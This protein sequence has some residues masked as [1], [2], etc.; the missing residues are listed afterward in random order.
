M[1]KYAKW[2]ILGVVIAIIGVCIFFCFAPKSA[3]TELKLGEAENNVAYSTIPTLGNDFIIYNEKGE[4]WDVSK[5]SPSYSYFT[6]TNLTFDVILMNFVDVKQFTQNTYPKWIS[7]FDEVETYFFEESQGDFN[8][9]FNISVADINKNYTDMRVENKSSY[10]SLFPFTLY[11]LA[12]KNIHTTL[13]NVGE[14]DCDMLIVS[15]PEDESLGWSTIFW[16]KAT[17]AGYVQSFDARMI[18]SNSNES[19]MDVLC[20][21]IYHILGLPDLYSLQGDYVGNTDMMASHSPTSSTSA[22][23]KQKLGWYNESNYNDSTISNIENISSTGTYTLKMPKINGVN[24]YKFGI[25]GNEYFLAEPR[26][27]W[28]KQ[29]LVVNRIN[30]EKY[31]NMNAKS[32]EDTVVYAFPG[33]SYNPGIYIR[34]FANGNSVGTDKNPLF[35]SDGTRAEY[36]IYN[37]KTGVDGEITFDF[38]VTSI[39]GDLYVPDD[40]DIPSQIKDPNK[41]FIYV[42][43]ANGANLTPTNIYFYNSQ[44]DEWEEHNLLRV[45]VGNKQYF[46]FMYNEEHTKIKVTYKEYLITYE[47]ELPIATGVEVYNVQFDKTVVG[48]VGDFVN[49][50]LSG[51]SNFV[52]GIFNFFK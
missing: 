6:G 2:T 30:T 20:H 5:A 41:R 11:G 44:D 36:M 16:P 22:Y 45:Y 9:K 49:G 1:P 46:T 39:D 48:T 24:A 17:V 21:E 47:K 28:D 34:L 13:Q 14:G 19:R 3:T 18:I 10:N 38:R 27:V 8:V 52:S 4:V 15:V 29:Y 31:S 35:Y 23:F 12:E 51:F 7:I 50:A 40:G 32:H 37:I 25:N 26:I 42:R 33:S 43:D